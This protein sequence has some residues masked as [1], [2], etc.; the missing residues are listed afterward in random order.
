MKLVE[1][2]FAQ[3]EDD[4]G[5]TGN[6]GIRQSSHADFTSVL[7]SAED[8]SLCSHL[9][10][11][12]EAQCALGFDNFIG[13]VSPKSK[14][15][16]KEV[17]RNRTKRLIVTDLP[18]QYPF[19]YNKF[20]Y[21]VL[22]KEIHLSNESFQQCLSFARFRCHLSCPTWEKEG[23]CWAMATDAKHRWKGSGRAI[24]DT[25]YQKVDARCAWET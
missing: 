17:V 15:S 10:S 22:R 2:R 4:S 7:P 23:S 14:K 5:R 13:H 8:P 9:F 16:L 20:F 12:R 11:C 6:A 21:Q 19:S 25:M 24:V 3:L 1:Q 18:V